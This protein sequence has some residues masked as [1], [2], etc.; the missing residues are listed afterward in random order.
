MPS[1]SFTASSSYDGELGPSNG[2]LNGPLAWCSMG[3]TSG[4]EFLQIHVPEAVEICAIATQGHGY[5]KGKEHVTE[6][7]LKYSEDGREWQEYEEDG[8]L[9]VC[10][11]KPRC[12]NP[13]LWIDCARSAA[14]HQGSTRLGGKTGKQGAQ[15]GWL[16]NR[17][18]HSHNAMRNAHYQSHNT[19]RTA[20]DQG[21][22][23]G[24]ESNIVIRV[25]EEF[26]RINKVLG[27]A[28]PY[29]INNQWAMQSLT[30]ISVQV[31]FQ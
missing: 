27:S 16:G 15:S 18:H 30:Q 19:N 28:S 24:N 1:S 17:V 2:R 5:F 23:P 26:L 31:M 10:L 13:E 6:Y 8:K 9:K 3:I 25:Y 20:L 7:Y 12:S 22:T 29:T 11:F 14:S 4:T 21:A